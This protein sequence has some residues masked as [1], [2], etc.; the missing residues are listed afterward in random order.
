[1]AL[2]KLDPQ[3][4]AGLAVGD[5]V[6]VRY[7]DPHGRNPDKDDM[8]T[9]YGVVEALIGDPSSNAERTVIVRFPN[10]HW[11]E[12]RLLDYFGSQLLKEV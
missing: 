11:S 1:M 4:I 9:E 5:K 8:T 7:F 10:R 3:E 12:P 2:R 6:A